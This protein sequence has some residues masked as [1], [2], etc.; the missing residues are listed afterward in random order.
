MSDD[1]YGCVIG[2]FI[3]LNL[4]ISK[5]EPM[6]SKQPYTF[7][8]EL[9]QLAQLKVIS[10]ASR[11]RPTISG[12]I[13]GAIE[14]LIAASAKDELVAEAL[15]KAHYKPRLIAVGQNVTSERGKP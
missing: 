15:R 5:G 6:G 13:R 9:D 2:Q 14:D 12:L 7:H 1:V 8:I 4:S 3:S 11:G 10:E